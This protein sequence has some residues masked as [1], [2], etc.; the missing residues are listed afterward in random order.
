LGGCS[1]AQINKSTHLADSSLLDLDAGQFRG[2]S[3]LT[4]DDQSFLWTIP[5][6]Q[7]YLLRLNFDKSNIVKIDRVVELSGVP[8]GIDTESIAWLEP[9]K[10]VLGTESQQAKRKSD[11]VYIVRVKGDKA[12]IVEQLSVPYHKWDI[13]ATANNGIEGICYTADQ[14]VVSLEMTFELEGTRRTP[15]FQYNHTNK[16]WKMFWVKM[17]T[18]TGRLSALTCRQNDKTQDLEVEAIE[19]Y[20]GIGRNIHFVIPKQDDAT[21]ITPSVKHDLA[22]LWKNLPNFEGIARLASGE[23]V[24]ISD[25]HYGGN[26]DQTKVVI[27]PLLSS[28]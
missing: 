7:P 3:G 10:F 22:P 2:L 20:F 18:K 13:A 23:L 21:E 19:R 15:I 16:S 27:L 12:E 14:M 28:P 25:N 4:I 11:L 26:T 6:R 8:Q 24:I 17:T 1:S 9:D 5:E